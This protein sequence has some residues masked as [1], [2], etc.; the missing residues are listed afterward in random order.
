MPIDF[1]ETKAGTTGA[2]GK[3]YATTTIPDKGC[4]FRRDYSYMNY[5]DNCMDC[6]FCYKKKDEIRQQKPKTFLYFL[7][8]KIF[9]PYMY[10]T[11]IIMSRFC[12]PLYSWKSM[13]HTFLVGRNIIENKGQFILKT[14]NHSLLESLLDLISNNISSTQ[15]QLRFMSDESLTGTILQKRIAPKFSKPSDL[16]VVAEKAITLNIDTVAVFDPFIPGV[17]GANLIRLMP[18]LKNSGIKKLIIRQLF[19]TKYFIEI[20]K[21]FVS[22]RYV[23]FSEIQGDHYIYD[24]EMLLESLVPVIEAAEKN[25]LTL[26][27]CSNRHINDLFFSGN[28]CCQFNN[29]ICDYIKID[30]ELCEARSKNLEK[31]KND[32]KK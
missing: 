2:K 26:S 32:R 13:E 12:D 4:Y 21:T 25:N 1:V 16:L 14:A 19:P 30:K 29:P 8:E 15:L 28:N 10:R 18:L 17:N 5:P 24:N 6:E 20:L 3:Y 11:P 27:V 31:V 7:R 22:S 23:N 9:S